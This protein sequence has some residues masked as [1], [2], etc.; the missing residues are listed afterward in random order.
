M[1]YRI[2]KDF[3][4]E[5]KVPSD[6][7]YGVHTARALENFKL[8][9]Y[10]LTHRYLVK[11]FAKVKTAAAYANHRTG[12][13]SR[14]I[15]DAI[16]YA[17]NQ[18]IA[19]KYIEQFIIPGIQGG[20]GTSTNMNA[21]EVIANIALEKLGYE[22]GRYD[23]LSP[24]DHVN[25][26]QSTNDSY[27]TA[28][29]IAI[30][31]L[32]NEVERNLKLLRRA[33]ED[34]AN[35]FKDIMKM[36]RTQLEDAVP[37]ALGREFKVY[38]MAINRDV[39]R[40]H[41]VKE[42]FLQVNMGG[43]AI[44][45]G[46]S[47]HPD[48]RIAV[49]EE[50][51]KVT[52]TPITACED[53]VDGTQNLDVFPQLSSMLK[54]CGLNLRKIANDLR[55]MNSGPTTSIHEIDLPAIQA[56]SSIMPKKVNPVGAEFIMQIAYKI[57]G[58]DLIISEC[59][60]GEFELNAWEP[61]IA[62]AMFES[63]TLLRD[64]LELFTN[65][66]VKGITANKELCEEYFEHCPTAATELISIIGY[67]NVAQIIAKVNESGESYKKVA[68]ERGFVNPGFFDKPIN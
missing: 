22:K 15:C 23:I 57:L 29:K 25:A 48:Y 61:L 2:E 8:T 40:L 38:A 41:Q 3:I 28:I 53:L 5:F 56:G 60:V 13:I 20:A 63:L 4:G 10:H 9:D 30:Y 34:K 44:G 35:E 14:E 46:V 17:S 36:G 12:K 65:T 27:P 1:T 11:A 16:V 59:T 66:V 49:I 52:A 19:G 18:I 51:R 67:D 64:G 6:A 7:Y 31:E 62:D 55:L 37:I 32:V 42:L 39:R 21:N 45:T 24:I 43:D 26:S 58:N 50:L 54:I 33:L 68:I 47:N